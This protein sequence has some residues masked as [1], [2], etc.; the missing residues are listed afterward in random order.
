MWVI[1][2]LIDLAQ[3]TEIGIL[4]DLSLRIASIFLEADLLRGQPLLINF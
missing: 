3:L 1:L 4:R 2:G